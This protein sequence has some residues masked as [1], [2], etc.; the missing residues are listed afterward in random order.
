[1]A[2]PVPLIPQLALTAVEPTVPLGVLPLI[3][4]PVGIAPWIE[5][6]NQVHLTLSSGETVYIGTVMALCQLVT[7]MLRQGQHLIC[8]SEDVF[9]ALAGPGAKIIIGEMTF[10]N[11]KLI[12]SGCFAYVQGRLEVWARNGSCIHSLDEALQCV[13]H[14]RTAALPY[15]NTADLLAPVGVRSPRLIVVDYGYN[16]ATPQTVTFVDDP[17]RHFGPR[18]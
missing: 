3:L 13:G 7:T 6:F 18:L 10:Q 16:P 11:Q 15:A 9:I 2:A 1:M 4:P 17:I 5:A 8:P 12:N 14:Y